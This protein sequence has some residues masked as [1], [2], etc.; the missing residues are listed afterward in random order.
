MVPMNHKGGKI[1]KE[2]P[3]GGPGPEESGVRNQGSEIRSQESAV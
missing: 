1:T 2:K 3:R